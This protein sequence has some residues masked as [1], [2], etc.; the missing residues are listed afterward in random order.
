MHPTLDTLA[1]MPEIVKPDPPYMQ[2]AE[3]L[4]QEIRTGRRKPGDV[5]PTTQELTVEY[6]VA[7]S[8]A[9]RAL[10]LLR[11]GGWIVTRPSKAALV[12][13]AIP[14]ET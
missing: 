1:V 11:D 12:A 8:T 2:V 3:H 14:E 6:K 4:R 10:A 9:A 7:M 13:P 5:M